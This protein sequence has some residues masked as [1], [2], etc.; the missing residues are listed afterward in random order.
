MITQSTGEP[1]IIRVINLDFNY[2]VQKLK[3]AAEF[4]FDT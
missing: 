2:D 4:S 1:F 3:I